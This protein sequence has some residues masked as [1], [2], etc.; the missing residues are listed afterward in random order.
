M[1][2][3]ENVFSHTAEGPIEIG[4]GAGYMSTFL[5]LLIVV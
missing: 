4:C 5:L 3:A 2:E 1:K